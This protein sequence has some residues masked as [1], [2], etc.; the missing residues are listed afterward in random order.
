[1]AIIDRKDEGMQTLLFGEDSETGT[2]RCYRVGLLHVA[3]IETLFHDDNPELG[4]DCCS[5]VVHFDDGR[6][7]VQVFDSF[8]VFECGCD[9]R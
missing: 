2:S 3:S 9:E 4:V 7:P 1:M 5:F 6:K 8:A